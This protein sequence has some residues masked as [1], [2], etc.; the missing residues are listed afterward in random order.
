[1]ASRASSVSLDPVLAGLGD[2][3]QADFIAGRCRVR[4]FEDMVIV[5][6]TQPWM[7]ALR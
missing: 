3:E 2:V 4:C 6:Y 1:M 5:D 7:D